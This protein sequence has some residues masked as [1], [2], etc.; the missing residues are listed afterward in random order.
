MVA[1]LSSS[2]LASPTSTKISRTLLSQFY[3]PSSVPLS[4]SQSI[5]RKIYKVRAASLKENDEEVI[6]EDSFRARTPLDNE[7]KEMDTEQS[8][9]VAVERWVI[10]FEQSV[11][12]FLIV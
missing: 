5:S 6:A 9:P 2:F 11:N 10:K 1:A 7:R 4:S 12:V 8:E 3:I